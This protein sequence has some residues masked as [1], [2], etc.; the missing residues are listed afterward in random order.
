MNIILRLLFFPMLHCTWLKNYNK[1]VAYLVAINRY[2]QACEE[3]DTVHYQGENWIHTDDI[4]PD[5]LSTG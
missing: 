4:V 3:C 1:H 5:E 2:Q